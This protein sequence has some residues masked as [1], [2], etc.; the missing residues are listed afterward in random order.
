MC[1]AMPGAPSRAGRRVVSRSVQPR[2]TIPEESRWRRSPDA[3]A[4]LFYAT[5]D[6]PR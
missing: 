1:G 4:M 6:A 5:L 3:A 2:V